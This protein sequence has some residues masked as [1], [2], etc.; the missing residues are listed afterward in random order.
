M[1]AGELFEEDETFTIQQLAES[2]FRIVK[3]TTTADSVDFYSCF[4]AAGVKVN[5]VDE[6]DL[7]DSKRC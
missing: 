3:N 7:K 5:S 1:A 2:A 6:Y 4:E